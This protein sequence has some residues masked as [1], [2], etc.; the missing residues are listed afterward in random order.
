[1][2]F[3]ELLRQPWP[4]YISGPL[5][6]LMVPA[7]LLMGN[8][9][10]G[11]SSSLRHICAACLPAKIPFFQYNWKREMWNLFFVAGVL[12]GGFIAA[13]LLAN[14]AAVQVNPKLAEELSRYGISDYHSLVPTEIFNWTNLFTLKG[15]IIMIGG[16]FLVGFGTRYAGG[17]TSGHSIMGL[18][19]LQWSSL[20]ATVCFMAGGFIMANFILPFIL[21]L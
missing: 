12:M 17:C 16:G 4:W 3:L 19:N 10:F 21:N 18:S 15:F 2:N 13:T 8:K 11:I 6:G 9:N 7:L 14:P 5:I 20:V 1:M